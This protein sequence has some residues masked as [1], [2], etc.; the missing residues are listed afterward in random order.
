VRARLVSA[1]VPRAQVVSG[2]DLA[3]E[4]PKPAVRAAPAGSVYWFE[5]ME[6]PVDGLR[7]LALEGLWASGA[8]DGSRRAEG[9]NAVLVAAW[10][11]R[12]RA[13]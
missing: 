5:E 11:P 3:R 1:C 8:E 9:F 10:P 6:G 12:D 13:N 2:W 4:K 7:R